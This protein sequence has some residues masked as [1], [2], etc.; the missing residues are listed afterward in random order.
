MG[1]LFRTKQAGMNGRGFNAAATP[2][3]LTGL[4]LVRATLFPFPSWANG[5]LGTTPSVQTMPLFAR[6]PRFAAG[7][8][9]SVSRPRLTGTSGP[10]L[11]AG[12]MG[13]T[14][15][16]PVTATPLSLPVGA[17]SAPVMRQVAPPTTA[18]VSPTPAVTRPLVAPIG[19]AASMSAAAPIVPFS[20]MTPLPVSR[21]AVSGVPSLPTAP[22][23]APEPARRTTVA[24]PTVMRAAAAPSPAS[25]ATP[26]PAPV[27]VPTTPVDKTGQVGSGA[28]STPGAETDSAEPTLDAEWSRLGKIMRLHRDK[29][30]QEGVQGDVIPA[31]PLPQTTHFQTMQEK[32]KRINTPSR[33][34]PPGLRRRAD[35]TMLSPDQ[36]KGQGDMP[37][38]SGESPEIQLTP[39]TNENLG[40]DSP[41]VVT[42]P[43]TAPTA[44]ISAL[45]SVMREAS[46]PIDEGGEQETAE[47]LAPA[48]A[49]MS[50]A[51]VAGTTPLQRQTEAAPLPVT[52]P[53]SHQPSGPTETTVPGLLPH[54]DVSL[55][56]SRGGSPFTAIQRQAEGTSAAAMAGSISPVAKSSPVPGQT[57]PDTPTGSG[58]ERSFPA[59]ATPPS[60]A[61]QLT[62][63]TAPAPSTVA[64]AV[65]TRQQSTVPMVDPSLS[66][67]LATSTTTEATPLSSTPIRA[68]IPAVQR[69]IAALPGDE[70]GET[71]S[72]SP[73]DSEPVVHSGGEALTLAATLSER[74]GEAPAPVSAAAPFSP[75]PAVQRQYTA[76]QAEPILADKPLL[77]ATPIRS[78]PVHGA[79][80]SPSSLPAALSPVT[81]QTTGPIVTRSVTS[82]TTGPIV[83][84]SVTSQTT[85]PIV[86]RQHEEPPT[87]QLAAIGSIA[88]AS[89]VEP[90]AGGQHI[91][92]FA[93]QSAPIASTAL[94]PSAAAEPEQGTVQRSEMASPAV[95]V[96]AMVAPLPMV[97]AR[98]LAE[99]SSPAPSPVQR[100]D[101]P[102]ADIPAS[103]GSARSTLSEERVVEPIV[104]ALTPGV[105]PAMR[106]GPTAA[107]QRTMA[108][109]GEAIPPTS[110]VGE[111]P[112]I[113]TSGRGQDLATSSYAAAS[114]VMPAPAS[115]P[116]LSPASGSPPPTGGVA[117][118]GVVQRAA[119]PAT[120]APVLPPSIA[121]TDVPTLIMPTPT[122]GFAPVTAQQAG[123][124]AN[125]AGMSGSPAVPAVQR[126]AD[127]TGAAPTPVSKGVEP[128]SVVSPSERVSLEDVWPVQRKESAPARETDLPLEPVLVEEPMRHE[129]PEAPK[130]EQVMRQVAAAKPS[131]SS[132]ELILPR[133]QRPTP[134]A[135]PVQRQ[136]E[137]KGNGNGT[138]T[139]PQAFVPT[140]IGPLPGD[141]WNILG[142]PTPT[143]AGVAE[144]PPVSSG[145]QPAIMRAI[146]AAEQ[147]T[148]TIAPPTYTTYAPQRAVN[149][150]PPPIQ[151]VEGEQTAASN[152]AQP[153]TVATVG[154]GV[155]PVT[156]NAPGGEPGAASQEKAEGAGE[157]NVEEL[158]R[159]VYS[160]VKRRLSV[161]WERG[162]GRF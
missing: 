24:A 63:S 99:F 134:P 26:A 55:S 77:P 156:G 144:A 48:A 122:G 1:V 146:A 61:I 17:T 44:A 28:L 73:T 131:D 107:V 105:V 93:T 130:V 108:E 21:S 101:M 43:A 157:V 124:P 71:S 113:P 32:Q 60:S 158:A 2:S 162:R 136:P 25:P 118:V 96:P 14:S 85:G 39:A 79:E 72:V 76:P 153:T 126:Q 18:V 110:Q 117:P 123:M 42:S 119:A 120:P 22:L 139:P 88:P 12:P 147:S 141:L 45:T 152:Q 82:Q 31:P 9:G 37:T 59:P 83:T 46:T 51:T 62:A 29:A 109:L 33:M 57:L 81:S 111:T 67:P 35:V 137:N 150:G 98:T 145:T 94:S 121:E 41:T 50:T 8:S 135:S 138:R 10:S 54:P 16:T 23:T 115:T 114:P 125:V 143:M 89:R 65:P 92:P 132:V 64:P 38:T 15:L 34:P 91:E 58:Q 154:S 127:V 75:T 95:A 151:R 159:Q 142:Q 49:P 80:S 140:E 4:P 13:A 66:A 47:Q 133:R 161:E 52:P 20:P 112:P 103:S 53:L 148:T 6:E 19:S 78:T 87:A 40:P 30:Q 106:V 129:K 100:M 69:Q 36:M 68:T 149:G 84:R 102:T 56:S 5:N 104:P 116:P 74:R 97:K 155:P 160:E 128:H 11:P 27:M 7:E 86:A 90:I 70:P 3:S